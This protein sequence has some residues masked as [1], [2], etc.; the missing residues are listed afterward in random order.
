MHW[1]IALLNVVP[2]CINAGLLLYTLFVLPKNRT[3][4]LFALFIFLLGAVQ[5]ADGMMRNALTEE[6]AMMWQ[7]IALSPWIFIAPIGVLFLL[8]ITQ[9][10]PRGSDSWHQSA[11]LIP[12]LI[13]QIMLSARLDEHTMVYDET[14]GWIGN[15][16]DNAATITILMYITVTGL[17]M[18]VLL[19]RAYRESRQEKQY[20]N[21]FL[22]LA[23]GVAIPYIG[24]V[25]GEVILP[26]TLKV[27]ELPVS[28]PLMTTFSIA[29]MIAIRKHNLL[30]FS[31]IRQFDRILETMVE[32]V[33][34]VDKQGKIMYANHSFSAICR[35]EL[36]GITGKPIIDYLYHP[37]SMHAFTVTG[38]QELQLS[39]PL[40]E[41]IWVVVSTSPCLDG[42]GNEIGHT[43]VITDI[44]QLKKS[45]ETISRNEL[46]LNRAQ[47]VANVGS[48]EFS[49]T[50]GKSTWSAEACRIYGFDPV[51]AQHSNEEWISRIHPADL[52]SVMLHINDSQENLSD[53]DFE[54]R[55]QLP[56]GTIKYIHSISKYELDQNGRPIALFGICKDITE[57]KTAERK[58]RATSQ[59][60]ETYI[61]KSS[62]DMHAP[63]ASILG[64]INVS[65]LEIN[66][67]MAVRYLG[68][69]EQQ[70]KKLDSVRAE[71]I[72]AMHIKDASGI[73]EQ[74]HLNAMI[75]DI[76]RD[77]RMEEGFSRLSV[78][79]NIGAD[80]KLV[81]NEFLM[82]TILQNLIQN[83]IRYQDQSRE[84]PE[85]LIELEQRGRM[86]NITI[87]DN[88]VGIDPSLH[89][90]IFEMYF[91]TE[92]SKIGSGLGLYLVKKAVEKLDAKMSMRSSPGQGTRFTL[93]FAQAN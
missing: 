59:E 16:G 8:S 64:L 60:L 93:S 19:F 47:E 85:L 46:I 49:F 20:R 3:N 53:S 35:H 54:F 75:G 77:L 17:F 52:A 10:T 44:D 31:P 27:N 55:I 70:A 21:K 83:S 15:P 73:N 26:I 68:M 51:Q 63:L 81:A 6:S 42:R 36:P 89:D 18:P 9:K 57:M 72:R 88:G 39:C 2:A 7:H 65:R 37:Q 5:F 76:L 45:L 30:D 4:N 61:Y 80:K 92:E 67:T 90:K 34:I 29:A 41:G 69:I 33:V 13:C 91:K 86:T 43:C 38:K 11:L 82:R 78:N 56:D 24:A 84:R 40:G 14:W 71:F 25:F 50:T 87:E 23:I 28:S 32:G 12:A 79:V 62:H 74:I 48:W 58:L 22:L 1:N 66:D